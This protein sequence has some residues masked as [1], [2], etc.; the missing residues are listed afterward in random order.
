MDINSCPNNNKKREKGKASILNQL[1]K[2]AK[3]D[4]LEKL[5]KLNKLLEGY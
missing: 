1:G 4:E 3:L 5:D 2:L